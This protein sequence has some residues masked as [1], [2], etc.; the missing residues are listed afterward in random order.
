MRLLLVMMMLWSGPAQAYCRLALALALDVSSSVDEVEYALQS[1]GLAQA[2]EDPEV[3][4]AFLQV[5][6]GTV[7]LMVYEWSGRYQQDVVLQW[8]AISGRADLTAAVAKLRSKG[9]TYAEFPTSIGFALGFGAVQF[10][11]APQCDRQVI[12]ISGDGINNDGFTPELAIKE[13]DFSSTVV[14]GLVIGD[15]AGLE[16]YYLSDVIHGPDAFVEVAEEFSDFR[17]AMKR[18][19]IREL[20]VAR[21][22]MR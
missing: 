22:G 6:G 7:A 14:N 1:E 5:P 20:G 13:F 10:R 18:K 4:D 2:L 17:T 15:E 11:D 21:L 8:H 3:V 12:D 19:L 16:S 9:R